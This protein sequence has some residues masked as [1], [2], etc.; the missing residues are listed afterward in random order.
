MSLASSLAAKI[1]IV[2]SAAFVVNY[3]G[4]DAVV[5]CSS[6]GMEIPAGIDYTKLLASCRQ[7]NIV[8]WL[9]GGIA[10]VGSRHA[11]RYHSDCRGHRSRKWRSVVMAWDKICSAMVL[12]QPNHAIIVQLHPSNTI[13][14]IDFSLAQELR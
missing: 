4:V 2:I 14:C 9:L 8:G 6:G 11:R 10:G 1:P 12:L 5:A 13:T 7:T 3:A